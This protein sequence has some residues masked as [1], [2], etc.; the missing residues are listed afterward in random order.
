M[1]DSTAA[2]ETAGVYN[3]MIQPNYTVPTK[4]HSALQYLMGITIPTRRATDLP[5]AVLVQMG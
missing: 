4:A 5:D 1:Q 2:Q 3:H